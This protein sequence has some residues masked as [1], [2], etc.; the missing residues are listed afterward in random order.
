MAPFKVNLAS[1][2]AVAS[3]MIYR[4][5]KTTLPVLKY[6]AYI[7]S[8]VVGLTAAGLWYYQQSMLYPA[9]FPEGSRRDVPNPYEVF[10][11]PYTEVTLTTP[12]KVSLAAYL[13]PARPPFEAKSLLA[14]RSAAKAKL[15][16]RGNNEKE[17]IDPAV[18][19]GKLGKD[20]EDYAKSRP[21][22]IMYHANAGNMGHRLPLAR[23]FWES[24]GCNVFMLSYRGY[25]KSEG[26][27]S[28]KGLRIDA[29]TALDYVRQHP[30]LSKTKVIVYG[31][32]IGGCVSV[33]VASRNGDK[34]DAVII[35]NAPFSLKSLIPFVMPLA[36]PFLHIPFLLSEKWDAQLSVPSIPPQTPFL[37]LVGGKDEIVHSTQ[38]PMYKKLR[39][40]AG[41]KITWKL[42][43]NGQH[44]DTYA[45]PGYWQAVKDFI[46]EEVTKGEKK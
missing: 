30:L 39:E 3:Y 26:T 9:S 19:E 28:E 40:K 23:V 20:G 13:I 10:G 15:G 11:M 17:V 32:S 5:P 16:V 1:G 31:Q 24:I 8:T 21:T 45:Q 6:L 22:V 33:D 18:A 44:N 41:G 4:Y 12:D 7:G 42:F 34:V 25:G 29:Q 36:G 38:M 35:E 2:L 46:E 43:P 27:P 37:A 14:L